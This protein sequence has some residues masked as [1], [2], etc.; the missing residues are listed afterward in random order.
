MRRHRLIIR[1]I[2]A[3]DLCLTIASVSTG[4]S[5]VGFGT[6]SHWHTIDINLAD[7]RKGGWT[8]G[9]NH[10]QVMIG[11][12]A[13][14]DGRIQFADRDVW[15]IEDSSRDLAVRRVWREAG[16]FGPVGF[17]RP[18]S[19][20][21][22][23]RGAWMILPWWVLFMLSAAIGTGL[24]I[25]YWRIRRARPAD[26]IACRGC[27]YDIRA[28]PDYC[29][30]CGMR[31]E[32]L[33]GQPDSCHDAGRRLYRPRFERRAVAIVNI[34]ILLP[35]LLIA[36]S[37]VAVYLARNAIWPGPVPHPDSILVPTD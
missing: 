35:C 5:L 28:S 34:A 3:I 18:S 32:S 14:L 16:S 37:A 20:G 25:V 9:A 21:S 31:V 2:G 12:W 33:T 23:A 15:L 27:G 7:A 6:Y 36:V 1:V 26:P 30:E 10:G 4:V 8:I 19:N 13:T 11:L 24:G 17:T 29:P 22:M